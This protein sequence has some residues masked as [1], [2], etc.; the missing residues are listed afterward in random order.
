M[1]I[2]SD[3]CSL[4]ITIG[5]ALLGIHPPSAGVRYLKPLPT[6]VWLPLPPACHN[7]TA[8]FAPCSCTNFTIGFQASTC[9]SFQRPVSFG[10]FIPMGDMAVHSVMINEAP[11]T[12]RLPKCT[13][14]QLF[15]TPSTALYC[16][17]GDTAIRLRSVRSLNCKAVNR[18]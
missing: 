15:G 18:L 5:E 7:C 17:I 2:S 12:A 4:F 11:P 6:N 3:L 14:C 13:R 10:V 16:C 8:I 1:V 9:A